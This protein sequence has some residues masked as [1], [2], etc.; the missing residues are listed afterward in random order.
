MTEVKRLD[1]VR[2]KIPQSSHQSPGM[3][4]Y[5]QYMIDNYASLV[6]CS[7]THTLHMPVSMHYISQLTA[8]QDAA[9]L[10]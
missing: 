9:V 4:S 6:T 7:E 3:S 10:D 8:Q 5:T 2:N 1:K